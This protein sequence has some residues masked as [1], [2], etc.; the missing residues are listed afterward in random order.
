M[1]HIADTIAR[2]IM[3]G[4]LAFTVWAILDTLAAYIER[5]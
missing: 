5:D 4:V 3:V 1:Q 2:L